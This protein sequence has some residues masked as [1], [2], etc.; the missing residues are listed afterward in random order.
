[1]AADLVT[2]DDMIARLDGGQEGLRELAGDDN[3]GAYRA[4]RVA[5]ARGEAT[6]EGYGILL[7]GFETVEKVQ[8]LVANDPTVKD[9]LCQLVRY[10]LSRWKKAFRLPDGTSVFQPEAREARDLLREK[11][12]GAKRTSAEEVTPDGPGRST[13]LRPRTATGDRSFLRDAVTGRPR[14]F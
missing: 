10:S 14:G 6:E 3:T 5:I 12:R 4:D 2:D 8:N 11:S 13:L 9:A 1:M 7:S